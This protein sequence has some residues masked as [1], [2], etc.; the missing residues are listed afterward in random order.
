MKTR[1]IGG[2]VALVLAVIGTALLVL[3][4]GA[5]DSRAQEGLAPTQ[6]LVVSERVPAG[7]STEDLPTFLTTQS[8]VK[9]AVA[10]RALT[11]LDGQE[12]K[13]TA[14]DLLPGEQLLTE[15]LVAPEDFAPGTVPVPDGLEEVTILLAPERMLGGRITAGD[16]VGVYI[17]GELTEEAPDFE[18]LPD[19]IKGFK[20]H[21]NLS[22]QNV[23]VTAVQQAAPQTEDSADAEGIAMPSGSAFVTLA[24][25]DFD[26]GRVIFGAEFGSIWFT[27][28]SDSSEE[29]DPPVITIPEVLK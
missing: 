4:V 27:K 28:E 24:L 22:L 5:A 21:T 19:E 29:A 25:N 3:Y 8:L 16:D 11:T 14:V 12:N 17:S 10:P 23:L 7:T 9:S 1:L 26:S 18:R 13:I 20:Q 15:R 6:V 2:L